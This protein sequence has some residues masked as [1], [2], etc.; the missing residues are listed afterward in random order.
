MTSHRVR[1]HGRISVAVTITVLVVWTLP[2]HA[3]GAAG[4]SHGSTE[5]T[6][7]HC[8]ACDSGRTR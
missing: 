4:T 5:S 3:P 7:T 1:V 8:M 2:G 6:R